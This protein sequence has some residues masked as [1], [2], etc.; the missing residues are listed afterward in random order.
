MWK[1]VPFE[2][3]GSSCVRNAHGYVRSV[4]KNIPSVSSEF[5]HHANI[6]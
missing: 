3:C 5:M 1:M 2:M 6:H 4:Q